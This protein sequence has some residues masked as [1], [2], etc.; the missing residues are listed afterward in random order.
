MIDITNLT[1]LITS[2]RNETEQG[3]ISPETLGA[4]LQAIANELNKAST[5]ADQNSKIAK[6]QSLVDDLNASLSNIQGALEASIQNCDNRFKELND[7]LEGMDDVIQGNADDISSLSSSVTN[8]NTRVAVV[9]ARRGSIVIDATSITSPVGNYFKYN[10]GDG[11]YELVR[12]GKLIGHVVSYM[13][14]NFRVFNVVGL[15]HINSNSFV[16]HDSLEHILVRINSSGQM[17]VTGTI[18]TTDLQN[19]INVINE[20]LDALT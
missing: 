10:M 4:L 2:F 3:S 13:Y 9:P 7:Y 6:L 14:N 1:S 17:F 12:A 8:L 15:C 5:E 20:R 19:Q 11:Y 18:D 16:Y